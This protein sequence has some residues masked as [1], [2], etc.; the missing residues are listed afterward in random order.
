M[1]MGSR[2]T[3]SPE[4]SRGSSAVTPCA[5]ALLLVLAAFLPV[6]ENGFVNYDDPKNILENPSFR[7]IGRPQIAW[8]WTT[9]H[10]GVYQP[11]GWMFL[12]AQYAAWGLDPRGY[13]LASLAVYLAVVIALYALTVALIARCRPELQRDRPGLVRAGSCLAVG[14]FAVHP[15]RVEPVAWVSCQSYL[16]CAL[17]AV[18]CV[19]TYLR[20]HEDDRRIHRGRWIGSV[21][22]FA[23]ALLSKA[24]A[25]G[26]PA[27]LLVLEVYPL[28]R[29]GRGRWLG[30]E[31]RQVYRALVPFAI[32]S[33]VFGALAVWARSQSMASIEG[34]TWETRVARAGYGAWFYLSKT[35]APVRISACYPVPLQLSLTL[36]RFL[37]STLGVAA[38]TAVLLALRHRWPGLLATWLVYLAML[39]PSS[40]LVPTGG[41]YITADR[42]GFLPTMAFVPL[43]AAGLC[44]LVR[45]DRSPRSVKGSVLAV[46]FVAILALVA[47]TGGQCRTWRDSL[48]LWSHAVKV[49]TEPN[50]FA[51][52]RLGLTLAEQPGKLAEAERWISEAVRTVPDDPAA[53]NAMTIVLA[54]QGRIEEALAQNREVLRLGPQNVNALVNLGNLRVMKGDPAG[55]RA[56]Y[57]GALRI[58]PNRADAHGNLGL[59]LLGQGGPADAKSHLVEALRLNPAMIRERRA[60]E[61]LCR[62]QAGKGPSSAAP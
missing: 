25:L 47:Q 21:L 32:L 30:P 6:R 35:I 12:G 44:S 53:R 19:L 55:A 5:V 42:Y 37:L 20:A 2:N 17:F 50:P 31:A 43:V 10:L 62:R 45:S 22:L 41:Q 26:L 61:D 49:S 38:A 34:H 60:L 27:V 16:P 51:S 14:L 57:E 52:H 46:V 56:A 29:L 59:L 40:G 13:H 3:V 9:G 58:D 15:L 23:A 24:A 8:A 48:A 39:V 33:A 18:L 28:G 54:K 7:G 36:P 11:L 4:A 1:K